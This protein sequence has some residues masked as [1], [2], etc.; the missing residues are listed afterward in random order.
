VTRLLREL[1]PALVAEGRFAAIEAVLARLP[2]EVFDAEPWLAYWRGACRQPFDV[3]EA[4]SAFERCAAS[5]RSFHPTRSSRASLSL[6]WSR[7]CWEHRNMPISQWRSRVPRHC[8]PESMRASERARGTAAIYLLM[9]YLWCGKFALA[10][11]T[12]A[13]LAEIA[14]QGSPPP[15][16][17]AFGK[18]AETWFAWLVGEDRAC[19]ARMN[20]SL[21]MA[22]S[23]GVHIWD[24]LTIVHGIASALNSGDVELA[25]QLL[26]RLKEHLPRAAGLRPSRGSRIWDR[27][28]RWA[29]PSRLAFQ[30][31]FPHE[32]FKSGDRRQSSP[33]LSAA[34][35]RRERPH[36]DHEPGQIGSH[37]TACG[38][39]RLAEQSLR[40]PDAGHNER[41]THGTRQPSWTDVCRL[42]ERNE[43]QSERHVLNEV[44]LS[45][46]AAAHGLVAAV[47]AVDF[48]LHAPCNHVSAQEQ[49]QQAEQSGSNE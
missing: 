13:L 6:A 9:Y 45:A 30:T 26:E 37:E 44:P 3:R 4:A 31:R 8:L 40:V 38:N 43:N 1:A 17:R 25:E 22:A 28:R 19:L 16:V 2:Q 42:H 48:E 33:K 11:R 20:E 32:V 47:A 23:T 12:S 39:A 14:S 24:F 5:F 35:E 7:S 27:C 49:Q 29:S 34:P 18:T 36:Q 15:I 10:Q 46:H 41:A 21:E